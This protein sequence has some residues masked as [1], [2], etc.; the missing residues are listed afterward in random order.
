MKNLLLFFCF[1]PFIIYS[2]TT[3]TKND[4]PAAGNT[5]YLVNSFLTTYD[6]GDTGPNYTW[7]FSDLDSLSIDTLDYVTVTQTP[8]G[9]QFAFNN[10]FDPDYKATEARKGS[11]TSLGQLT[12]TDVYLYTKTTSSKIEEVGT[13]MS[14]NGF[15][16]PVK[17]DDIKTLFALPMAFGNN[18][19]DTYEYEISIPSLGTLGQEGTITYVVDGWGTLIT[20]FGTYDALR[21]K[22]EI[23]KSD[24]FY[25]DNLG[26]GLRIPSSQTMYQWYAKNEGVPVLSI[27]KGGFGI[28]QSVQYKTIPLPAT[29][30]FSQDT[31]KGIIDNIFPVPAS[32]QFYV[33]FAPESSGKLEITLH[34][35]T[36]LTV[37]QR[38]IP[39]GKQILEIQTSGY[40]PG[41]YLLSVK[42]SKGIEH[43][44]IIIE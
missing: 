28:V 5:Y 39:A 24:T 3:I 11:N 14:I 13:G 16:V 36:G 2:Q 18:G 32:E 38:T 15:P 19:T 37:Y 20:P 31:K 22:T 26:F 23:N 8:I 17:Y 27:T 42:T 35:A 4:L 21:I 1:A 40:V 34:S 6:D 43:R 7:D 12:L 10:P 29:G 44:T 25:I 33:S 41:I 9:Y 30:I